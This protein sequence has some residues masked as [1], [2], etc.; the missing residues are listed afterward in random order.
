MYHVRSCRCWFACVTRSRWL[1]TTTARSSNRAIYRENCSR[2]ESRQPDEE[3]PSSYRNLSHLRRSQGSPGVEDRRNKTDRATERTV[4]RNGT[5]R[6]T[7]FLGKLSPSNANGTD[8]CLDA[9]IPYSIIYNFPTPPT[10]A[11]PLP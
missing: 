8:Q 10:K 11:R 3:S 1:Y 5:D 9:Y 2:R 7:P 4:E 6:F